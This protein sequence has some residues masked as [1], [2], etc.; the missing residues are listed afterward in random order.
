[1]P[2]SPHSALALSLTLLTLGCSESA[3]PEQS[4]PEQ[5]STVPEKSATP[6]ATV[7]SP[8]SGT[9]RQHPFQPDQAILRDGTLEIRQG[10]DFFP[11]LAVEIVTFEPDSLA[12]RTLTADTTP[13]PHLRLGYKAPDANLPDTEMVLS[14][15]QLQLSFGE[16]QPLGLPYTLSLSVP[17]HGTKLSGQGLATFL[18]IALKDGKIDRH[19]DSFD[20]LDYLAQQHLA[21]S[22]PAMALGE[23]FG[24]TLQSFGD[25]HPKRGVIG[26]EVTDDKGEASTLKVLL[27]KDADG[28]QVSQ[29]LDTSQLPQAHQALPASD[30]SDRTR[31]GLLAEQAAA[32]Y[33]ETELNREGQMPQVR[34]SRV[35][36]RLTK[37]RDRASCHTTLGM[38][39]GDDTQCEIRSHLLSK[40]GGEWQVR[41]AIANDQQVN[42]QSGELEPYRPF[43]P[44]CE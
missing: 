31:D 23:R 14:G 21:Q 40:T 10:T 13:A 20:T 2:K 4:P 41:E 12:G 29:Q 39:T 34:A 16:A 44:S 5:N 25:D 32:R 24:V 38:R 17:E 36:C 27:R 37:E 6:P 26:F 11:D 35:S 9:L 1:M 15:Y 22:A 28:W 3:P 8:V 43:T 33:L 18:D 42:Y 30:L 19:W 7:A